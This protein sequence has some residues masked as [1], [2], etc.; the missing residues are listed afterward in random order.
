[1][2]KAKA[3]PT[4]KIRT[5]CVYRVFK[6]LCIRNSGQWINAT[7]ANPVIADLGDCA[8]A[9]LRILLDKGYI[10]T[11]EGEPINKATGAV[12]RPPCPCTKK[13]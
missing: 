6:S 8:D 2:T 11:A 5:S 7:R 10:E 1:L 12:N 13:E 3:E 9:S 4:T